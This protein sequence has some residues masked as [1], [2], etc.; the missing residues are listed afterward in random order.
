MNVT[1]A[2]FE[3]DGRSL[4]Y[5]LFMPEENPVAMLQIVHDKGENLSAY[6]AL[7]E[8]LTARGVIVFGCDLRGHGGNL[9]EHDLC[10]FGEGKALDG[11]LVD[12]KAMYDFMRKKYRYLPHVL[13]G[14]GV[15]SILAR[16]FMST[17]HESTDG[18]VLTG[19]YEPKGSYLFSRLLCFVHSKNTI[20]LEKKLFGE[21]PVTH[22]QEKI[23]LTASSLAQILAAHQ[24]VTLAEFTQELEVGVP[25]AIFEGEEE[26]LGKGAATAMDLHEQL[27][28]AEF[29]TLSLKLYEKA[30]HHLHLSDQKEDFFSDVEAFIMQVAEGV[31]EAR[32]ARLYY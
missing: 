31:R 25:V 12:Q 11:L 23:P 15:G 24:K 16:L 1:K 29:C 2:C 26:T 17:F 4:C 19:V 20:A 18:V 28:L 9:K 22:E 13:L 6:Y 8:H 14:H 32:T 30:G 3:A 10:D 27:S 21:A 7:A 5:H